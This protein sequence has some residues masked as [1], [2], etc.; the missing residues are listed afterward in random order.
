M[1]VLCVVAVIPSHIDTECSH[2]GCERFMSLC[3]RHSIGVHVIIETHMSLPR[4][5]A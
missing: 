4:G 3:M 1:L 5:T 2:C